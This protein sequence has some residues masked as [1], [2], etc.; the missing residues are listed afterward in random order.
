MVQQKTKELFKEREIEITG[1]Y[2]IVLV[3]VFNGINAIQTLTNHPLLYFTFNLFFFFCQSE[4]YLWAIGGHGVDNKL[5][6]KDKASGEFF[7]FDRTGIWDAKGLDHA[8]LN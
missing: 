3:H 5:I 6:F 4:N 2:W 8:L 7:Y 1:H